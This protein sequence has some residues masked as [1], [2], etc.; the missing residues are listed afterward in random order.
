MNLPDF[1]TMR[2]SSV[3]AGFPVTFYH[4]KNSAKLLTIAPFTGVIDSD[5]STKIVKKYTL[6]KLSLLAI[7]FIF[8]RYLFN[9]VNK[10]AVFPPTIY[11]QISNFIS[12]KEGIKSAEY[13]LPRYFFRVYHL[14][15]AYKSTNLFE[16][17]SRNLERFSLLQSFQKLV[18]LVMRSEIKKDT[19]STIFNKPSFFIPDPS[20]HEIIY[21]IYQKILGTQTQNQ[22][23]T[24]RIV[25]DVWEKQ[26]EPV[27]P[28][29]LV[30][31][32]S[33]RVIQNLTPNLISLFQKL[34]Q[35]DPQADEPSIHSSNKLLQKLKFNQK[36]FYQSLLTKNIHKSGHSISK[37][38]VGDLS[39]VNKFLSESST[40]EIKKTDPLSYMP[41]QRKNK[42]IAI[43]SSSDAMVHK[44]FSFKNLVKKK[45]I[46]QRNESSRIHILPKKE[47]SN[48]SLPT[49]LQ[50]LAYEPF[51]VK[52]KGAALPHLEFP[53]SRYLSGQQREEDSGFS[54]YGYNGI[55]LTHSRPA[56][57]T[58]APLLKEE[59]PQFAPFEG[60]ENKN[61]KGDSE[62]FHNEIR[63]VLFDSPVI[64]KIAD[65]V[66]SILERRLFIE[67]ERRG[68]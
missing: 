29:P 57:I 6:I 19:R 52:E 36:K 61:F 63:H 40:S 65:Q 17:P 67:R 7:P 3:I 66:S 16:N 48:K 1:K 49:Y 14:L 53:H 5:W 23:L 32:L 45:G 13:K 41:L 60:I 38:T 46:L 2:F 44:F 8:L 15:K 11:R 25:K 42:T 62:I 58:S 26:S 10:S 30:L 37:P 22:E 59:T 35:T 27:L 68:L 28:N 50:E 9:L 43:K 4:T 56:N 64:H 12:E 20:D 55:D 39:E 33:K 18:P 54:G 51:S 34:S 24:T 21:S 31:F 47:L